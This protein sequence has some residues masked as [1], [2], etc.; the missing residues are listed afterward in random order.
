MAERGSIQG[1]VNNTDGQ[2]PAPLLAI[3]KKGWEAGVA[4]NLTGGFLVAREVLNQSMKKTD[5]TIVNMLPGMPGMGDSGAARAGMLNF[6]QTATVEW[7]FAGGES[8]P[9][10]LGQRNEES[11]WI[12]AVIC[13]QLLW[14]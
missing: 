8:W 2:Y 4:N 13:C 12:S 5:G 10:L 9:R 1:L 6:T 7:A 3:S 14:Q 11:K